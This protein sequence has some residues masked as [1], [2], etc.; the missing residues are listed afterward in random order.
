MK[1]SLHAIGH[2]VHLGH[3]GS[4]CPLTDAGT[5]VH[6]MTVTSEYGISLMSVIYCQCDGGGTRVEQLLRARLVP[7]T[8]HR[9]RHVFT[10]GALRR[11][12]HDALISNASAWDHIKK[13]EALTGIIV[14][15]DTTVG[16]TSR[17]TSAT[18]T[19]EVV[20]STSNSA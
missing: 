5:T 6:N 9:P 16:V 7:A 4:K 17:L 12:H 3:G 10:E 11:W 2:Q 13:L 8:L 14:E 20:D 18:F 15:A 1:T 19:H